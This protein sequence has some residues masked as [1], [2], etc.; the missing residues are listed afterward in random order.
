V[1]G[2]ARGRKGRVKGGGRESEEDARKRK[3]WYQLLV[4]LKTDKLVKVFN[5]VTEMSVKGEN[6]NLLKSQEVKEGRGRK[7]GTL[8]RRESSQYVSMEE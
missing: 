8:V 4:G 5:R 7:S 1:R 6:E 2:K 3:D